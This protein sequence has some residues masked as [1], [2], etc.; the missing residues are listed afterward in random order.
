[1]GYLEYLRYWMKAPVKAARTVW[2]WSAWLARRTRVFVVRN[3]PEVIQSSAVGVLCAGVWLIVLT[4]LP[5]WTLVGIVPLSVH[6][7]W[8]AYLM[9]LKAEDD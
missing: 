6:M 3:L 4:S 5:V 1:M 7:Y 9:D 2:F 8:E